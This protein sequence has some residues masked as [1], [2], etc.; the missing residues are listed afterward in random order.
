LLNLLI[1]LSDATCMSLSRGENI[2]LLRFR[3]SVYPII[4]GA[5]HLYSIMRDYAQI[6]ASFADLIT[7]LTNVR[8]RHILLHI[9]FT[10]KLALHRDPDVH[11]SI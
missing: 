3:G 10:I 6:F 7:L 8:F 5:L 9:W 11:P 1:V 2:I 4:S